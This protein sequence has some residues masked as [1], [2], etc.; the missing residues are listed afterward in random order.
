MIN[1]GIIGLGSAA[2]NFANCFSEVKNAKLY[3]VASLD[4]KKIKEFNQEFKFI[5]SYNSYEDL[6]NDKNID[7]IYI[8]TVNHLHYELVKKCAYAKKNIL[9]EKPIGINLEQ[10]KDLSQIINKNKVKC[11]EGIAYYLHPQLSKIRDIISEGAI[12][13]IYKIVSSFGYKSRY[14]PSSRIYNPKLGGG[15]LLDLACYP[16]SFLIYLNK[17]NNLIKF[18]KK[19]INY[20]KTKV[21][22]HAEAKLLLDNNIKA[23]ISVSIKKKMKNNCKIF[24]T[25]GYIEILNPWLPGLYETI[26]IKKN[27][28]FFKKKIEITCNLPVYANQLNLLSISFQDSNVLCNFFDINKSKAYFEL[29]EEWKKC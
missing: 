24:G 6:I 7:A 13:S 8:S 4:K 11:A 14:E 16:L 12:G 27:F 20:S 3:G 2:K 22:D 17:D 28:S 23:E 19:I 5:K 29:I 18:E 10:I 25:K 21:I 15:A 9:C 26:N 1:W